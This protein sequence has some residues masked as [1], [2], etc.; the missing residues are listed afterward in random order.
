[1][2]RVALRGRIARMEQKTSKAGK[3]Y[4]RIVVAV[5]R[6]YKDQNGQW[7]EVT[8]FVPVKVIYQNLI[9]K[10]EK[11]EV[12][13]EVVIEGHLEQYW[14]NPSQSLNSTSIIEVVAEKLELL[15]KKQQQPAQQTQPEPAKQPDQPETQQQPEPEQP[16]KKRKKKVADL[17]DII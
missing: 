6:A 5:R 17:D 14:T 10:L 13:D 15:R 9:P 3:S 8:S 11:I 4:Y 16:K 1:M 2:N 12:G 7:H